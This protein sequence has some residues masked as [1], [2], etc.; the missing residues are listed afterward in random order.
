M[1]Y[2]GM[3]IEGALP[4]PCLV[5]QHAAMILKL[6]RPRRLGLLSERLGNSA[7]ELI[8]DPDQLLLAL[9]STIQ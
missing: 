7:K 9:F 5:G 1:A 2:V 6:A 8:A 4:E 3:L